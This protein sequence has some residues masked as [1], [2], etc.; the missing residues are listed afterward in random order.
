MERMR[1][2]TEKE[3][4]SKRMRD[5]KS[6]AADRARRR[7]HT[8]LLTHLIYETNPFSTHVH[9]YSYVDTQAS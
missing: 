9:T 5:R 7:E 8:D 4:K 6:G 3:N 1:F 2:E